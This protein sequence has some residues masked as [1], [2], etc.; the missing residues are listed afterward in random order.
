M[1]FSNMHK[2]KLAEGFSDLV[3]PQNH[4]AL[5]KTQTARLHPQN[6]RFSRPG[7]SLH[8]SQVPDDAGAAGLGLHLENPWTSVMNSY[9]PVLKSDCIGPFKAF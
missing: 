5:L 2:S 9:L 1:K 4:V 3:G 7:M 8:F 6:I